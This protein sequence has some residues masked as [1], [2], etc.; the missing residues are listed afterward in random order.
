M[1]TKLAAALG[2]RYDLHGLLGRGGMGAVY[3]A[4]DTTLERQ[5]AIKLLPPEYAVDDTFVSRFEREARTAAKLDHPGIIPIYAVEHQDDLY[6]FVM[7]H[8]QGRGLDDLIPESGM[9]LD[10]AREILWEAAVA[11]GHAHQRGVVHRDIKPANIMIDEEGRALITDFGISKATQA[12]TQLT[13]TGEVIGT[14]H[15]MSP[16]Q[17]KGITVDGRSDQY[18]LAMAGYHMLT[19]RIPFGGESLHTVIYKQVFE[20]PPPVRDVRSDVSEIVAETI[21]RALRKEPDERFPTMEEFASALHPERPIRATGGA[22]GVASG[23]TSKITATPTTPRVSGFARP[24]SRQRRATTLVAGG[25]LLLIGGGAIGGVWLSSRGDDVQVPP[26]AEPSLT[27]EG[28]TPGAEEQPVVNIDSAAEGR[29]QGDADAPGQAETVAAVPQTTPQ[30]A[31]SQP[32]PSV[33][34][35]MPQQPQAGLLTINADPFGSVFVDGV[36]IGDT[37]VVRHELP[38]GRH[39]VE[40]R[41]EGYVTVADTL[42]VVAGNPYRLQ[43]TLLRQE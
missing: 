23:V 39:I 14:P 25:A 43:K 2:S 28:A 31:Q 12:A 4:T 34:P 5:V 24:A 18:S 15:Y 33:N 32:A 16:E 6:Y 36:P 9:D 41:R 35:T 19:G 38:P 27:M 17:A 1:A 29:M 37:P 20:D 11:L 13:A 3:R 42:D 7:K 21:H 40:V 22:L 10:F 30:P 8:V 26:T